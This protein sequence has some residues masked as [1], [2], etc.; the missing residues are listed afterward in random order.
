M[1]SAVSGSS[2]A[3]WTLNTLANYDSQASQ[4]SKTETVSDTF[5][6]PFAGMPKTRASY[7]PL[8]PVIEPPRA[9]YMLTDDYSS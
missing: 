4:T 9:E 7:L 5:D 3:R 6:R 1:V 2:I 8:S